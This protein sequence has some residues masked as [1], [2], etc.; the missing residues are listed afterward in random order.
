MAA[1]WGKRSNWVDY[2]ADLDGEKLG[3]AMFDHPQ[4]ARNPTY[5][6]AR[7]YGLFALNPFGRKAFDPKLEESLWKI[8]A[9]QKVN[10]RWGVVI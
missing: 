5:W 4:S 3:V 7:D 9:G 8:P 6:H 10:F 1:I 2:T